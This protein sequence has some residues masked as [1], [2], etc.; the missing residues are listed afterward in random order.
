MS[1]LADE[2][3]RVATAAGIT[4]SRFGR[5]AIND[6]TLWVD[7]RR[8]RVLGE[9]CAARIDAH[10]DLL[11]RRTKLKAELTALSIVRPVEPP[12]P[13]APPKPPVRSITDNWCPDAKQRSDDLLRR[14]LAFGQHSITDPAAYRQVCASVGLHA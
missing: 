14:Q 6:S 10:L 4:P 1:A 9:A 3:E 5:E 11:R 12:K 8:G 7:L 2:I 13:L